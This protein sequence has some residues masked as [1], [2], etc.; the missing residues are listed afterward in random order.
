MGSQD[1][2]V[3]LASVFGNGPTTIK[4]WLSMVYPAARASNLETL[5]EI[6]N[7]V[8]V[9]KV[10]AYAPDLPTVVL[11]NYVWGYG[12]EYDEHA[13]LLSDLLTVLTLIDPHWYQIK[14][15]GV[16]TSY[17]PPFAKA[18]DRAVTLLLTSEHAV[19]VTIA[20]SYPEIDLIAE[21]RKTFK[22]INI[23]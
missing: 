14:V 22:G 23:E 17:L 1:A 16:W 18:S 10:N 9:D 5:T 21:V 12:T 6:I 8:G 2:I 20:S 3:S 13:G 11:E 4:I 7:K 15:K 19:A